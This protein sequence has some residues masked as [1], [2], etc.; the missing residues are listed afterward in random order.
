M[1]VLCPQL[2]GVEVLQLFWFP[3]AALHSFGDSAL[4]LLNIE[5]AAA[6]LPK[7]AIITAVVSA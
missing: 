6:E 1:H 7:P 5:L 4:Q 3:V 2:F